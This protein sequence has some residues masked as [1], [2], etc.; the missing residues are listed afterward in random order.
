MPTERASDQMAGAD[1]I[2]HVPLKKVLPGLL[3]SAPC[4]PESSALHLAVSSSGKGAGN[5]F[6]SCAIKV[7]LVSLKKFLLL[8]LLPEEE[9]PIWG[10]LCKD[11][12]TPVLWAGHDRVSK[13]SMLFPPLHPS[14]SPSD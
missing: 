9:R 11:L 14:L 7:N 6:A 12:E 13:H 2:P 8:L 10:G 1:I 3:W 5:G 4:W